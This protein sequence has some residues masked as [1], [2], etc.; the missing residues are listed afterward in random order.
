MVD[1]HQHP[2]IGIVIARLE[3]RITDVEELMGIS[4]GVFDVN[5][6]ERACHDLIDL[7]AFLALEAYSEREP[8]REID[9]EDFPEHVAHTLDILREIALRLPLIEGGDTDGRDR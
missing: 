7:A 1:M 9:H 5:A 8:N 2:A 4:E 6:M 3:D